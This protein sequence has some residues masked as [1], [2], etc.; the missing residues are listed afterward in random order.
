MTDEIKQG[1]IAEPETV[2]TEPAKDQNIDELRAELE[3]LR[4]ETELKKNEIAT[5]DKK[6]TYRDWET[7]SEIGRAHV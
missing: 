1:Q 5:R 6:L 4:K 3:A 2:K 7:V